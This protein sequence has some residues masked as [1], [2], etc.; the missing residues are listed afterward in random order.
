M[1]ARARPT[2]EDGVMAQAGEAGRFNQDGAMAQAA[3]SAQDG[4]MSRAEE[5]VR[6]AQDGAME[7][8]LADGDAKAPLSPFSPSLTG[9]LST[10]GSSSKHRRPV[11][12]ICVGSAERL[13][14]QCIDQAVRRRGALVQHKRSDIEALCESVVRATTDAAD[15]LDVELMLWLE[16]EVLEELRRVEEEAK[17][18]FVL[19]EEQLKYEEELL[20]ALLETHLGLGDDEHR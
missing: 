9:S 6:P 12:T 18:E 4:A 20:A 15:D 13:R 17:K 2:Q 10:P 19:Y 1:T 11:K 5:A 16:L 14:Q 7:E 3:R 8:A